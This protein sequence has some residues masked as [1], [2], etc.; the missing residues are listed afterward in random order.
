MS[1]WTICFDQQM[2]TRKRHLFCFS[3]SQQ[4][5]YKKKKQNKNKEWIG[6]F[7]KVFLEEERMRNWKICT[8]FTIEVCL[9]N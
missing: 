5:P 8:V 3:R 9:H 6:T 2:S 4:E 1:Q 7:K